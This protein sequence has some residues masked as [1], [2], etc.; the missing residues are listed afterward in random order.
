M[1]ETKKSKK[2]IFIFILILLIVSIIAIWWFYRFSVIVKYN[3]DLNNTVLDLKYYE[4]IDESKLQ[5]RLSKDG[6][7]FN[8]FYETYII[9][10]EDIIRI[11]NNPSLSDSICLSGFKFDED[12]NKCISNEKF[13]FSTFRVKKDTTIEA[14][15]DKKEEE[16]IPTGRKEDATI[17]LSADNSCLVGVGSKISLKAKIEGYVKDKLIKWDLPKCYTVRRVSDANYIL[18]RDAECNDTDE[19]TSIVTV[20]LSNGAK[21]VYKFKYEPKLTFKVF[22]GEYKA[23]LKNG[24]Y[25][26]TNAKIDTNI[27]AT[28]KASKSDTISFTTNHSATLN[29]NVKDTITIETTCGQVET[30]K[31]SK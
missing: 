4:K 9:S 11:E 28:F 13:D 25:T 1:E 29:E 22:D 20:S 6:Y 8:G 12:D 26:A 7:I 30:V 21:S 5:D 14:F 31:V 27:Q 17:V 19:L 2:W 18:T 23:T 16:E 24:V 15:W 3:N 10:S